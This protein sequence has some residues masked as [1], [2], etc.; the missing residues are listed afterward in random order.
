M[1][2][3]RKFPKSFKKVSSLF[4]ENFNGISRKIKG[5]FKGVFGGSQGYL[6]EA[7]M[8]LQ[9]KLQMCFKKDSRVFQG[10]LKGVSMEFYVGFIGV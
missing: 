6:K 9:G 3:S 5:C 7:Q 8:E 2:V 1:G 4:Q 10:R